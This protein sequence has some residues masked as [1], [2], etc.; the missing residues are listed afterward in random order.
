[1][2][3]EVGDFGALPGPEDSEVDLRCVHE[4]E[5]EERSQYLSNLQLAESDWFSWFST[6]CD[7][8]EDRRKSDDGRKRPCRALGDVGK[9]GRKLPTWRDDE[10]KEERQKE[11]RE[12]EVFCHR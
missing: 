12:R 4:C 2:K 3:V 5:E 9:T 7:G 10:G 11:G 6:L 8:E 1:M